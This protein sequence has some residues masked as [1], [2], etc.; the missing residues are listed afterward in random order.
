MEAKEILARVKQLFNELAG[1][2]PPMPPAPP[3]EPTAA[4]EYELKIGGKV[5]I[6]KLEVGGIVVID[7]SPALPGDLEL[8]D[9]TKL[10][11]ADN[12]VISAVTPGTGVEPAEPVAEP[13]GGEDMGSK[14]AA[15]ETLTSA[16]FA[17]Y[18]SKFAAYENKFSEYELKLSKYK[19]M[20]DQLLQFGKLM[21]EAPQAQPDNSVKT[22]NAFKETKQKDLSILFN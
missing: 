6:D 12:G 16:K 13:T 19:E 7:G 11:V 5:T 3:T 9:G 14:F 21:V 2:P 8:V 1:A 10:T 15:F 18:E 20:I 22:Q 17:N 4:K